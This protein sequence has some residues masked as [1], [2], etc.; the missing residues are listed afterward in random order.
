ML[1]SEPKI[2]HGRESEL[3]DILDLFKN[4]IPKIAILGAGGMGKTTLARAVLHQAEIMSRYKQNR[5]FVACSSATTKLEL[6]NLIGAQLGL[7]P[8]SDAAFF[9]QPTEFADFG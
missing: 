8:G 2:F 3:S 5:F 9:N 1:P 7:K 4:R 6:V